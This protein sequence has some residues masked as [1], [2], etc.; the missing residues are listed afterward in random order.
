MVFVFFVIAALPF[1][2]A[3]AKPERWSPN[4]AVDPEKLSTKEL[5]VTRKKTSVCPTKQ[6]AKKRRCG[7]SSEFTDQGYVVSQ[8]ET[9]EVVGEKPEGK[10][11]RALRYQLNGIMP[12]WVLASD[13]SEKPNLSAVADLRDTP[14]DCLRVESIT[15]KAFEG[16]TTGTC[17]FLPNVPVEMLPR[18]RG[19]NYYLEI[20]ASGEGTPAV[21]ALDIRKLKRR[22][23]HSCMKYPSCTKLDYLCNDNAC[24]EIAMIVKATGKKVK[25]PKGKKWPTYYPKKISLWRVEQIADRY[26]SAKI[27][28]K[29]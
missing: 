14:T 5:I 29:K 7:N 23:V 25:R 2:F 21:L 10:Y 15:E 26:G 17:L 16:A 27:R 22:D 19:T 18:G 11:W 4:R 28:K 24:D 8:G 20:P 9:V 3:T 6:T 13:V 12:G 1:G